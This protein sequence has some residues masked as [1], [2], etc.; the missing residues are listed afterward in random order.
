MIELYIYSRN[1]KIKGK[2]ENIRYFYKLKR[3]YNIKEIK[4]LPLLASK[5]K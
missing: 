1:F 4:I 5:S 3:V 2:E